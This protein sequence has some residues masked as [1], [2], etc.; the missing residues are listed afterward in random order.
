MPQYK[1]YFCN[2]IITS[3]AGDDANPVITYKRHKVHQACFD[4]MMKDI[5]KEK[6]RETKQKEQAKKEE[7]KQK[8]LEKEIK[9]T[10]V[11]PIENVKDGLSEEEFKAKKEYYE[12]IRDQIGSTSSKHYMLT[13]KYRKQFNYTFSGM[14]QTLVYVHDVLDKEFDIEGNLVAIIPYYYEEAVSYLNSIDACDKAN[15]DKDISKMYKVQKIT[16]KREKPKRGETWD[17]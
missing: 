5:T 7:A 12:Y 13:E 16:V 1:C 11:Q 9:L 3:D 2:K 15:K 14:H 8:K 6:Q 4:K 10:Q 17:F